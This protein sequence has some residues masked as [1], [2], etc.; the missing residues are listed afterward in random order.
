MQRLLNLMDETTIRFD[1]LL[2]KVHPGQ[3]ASALNLLHYLALRSVDISDLQGAL[4]VRGLSTIANAEGYVQHQ[5][6]VIANH[7]GITTGQNESPCDHSAAQRILAHRTQQLFGFEQQEKRP[8]IMVTF[9]S[10]FAHDFI[11]V[12]KI[13]KAG[14]NIARINCAHNDEKTWL[15]MVQNVREVSTFT[16][17]GCRIYMD[18]AGPKIRTRIRNKKERIVVEE[19]DTILLTDRE[20][21]KSKLPV[22]ECTVPGISRQLKDGDRVFF[23]DGLIETRVTGFAKE[24]VELE[25]VRVASKKPFLKNEKGINFPDSRLSLAALSDFDRR[26]LPFIKEHTD[27]IGLSFI[28]DVSDL[29]E[30][31]SRVGDQPVILKIETPEAFKNLPF[32]LLKAMQRPVFGVMIARGDLAVELGFEQISQAQ[33]D[34]MGMCRAAHTPVVYATQILE[35][36]NK[37]GLPTRAE[38][39]D[40]SYGVNADCVMVNKGEHV[41]RVVRSLREILEKKTMQFSKHH[42]VFRP[43]NIA[44][45]FF[46]LYNKTIPQ[47]HSEL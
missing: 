6:R 33:E 1:F 16:G 13:L 5:L 27:I 23:D 35:N 45:D 44:C 28:R 2:R 31:Y 39:T 36:M 19:E 22:V 20:G 24:G 7:L 32:L 14:M 29:D 41:A 30:I 15:R 17:I 18:L 37:K 43:M 26:C 12:K 46:A 4:H 3:Y 42:P 40:A 34:I 11:T 9:Q 47:I 38:I 8:S 21:V 10:S 25:V